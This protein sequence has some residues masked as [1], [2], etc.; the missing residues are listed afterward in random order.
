MDKLCLNKWRRL[1]HH[2]KQPT[3]QNYLDM[4]SNVTT[5]SLL[6]NMWSIDDSMANAYEYYYSLFQF[7]CIYEYN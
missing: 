3:L 4:K 1:Y 6:N 7:A 5:L 2:F